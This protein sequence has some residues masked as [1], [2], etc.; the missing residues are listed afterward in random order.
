MAF[1]KCQRRRNWPSRIVP[2]ARSR[3]HGELSRWAAVLHMCFFL[4]IKSALLTDNYTRIDG[5]GRAFF[6]MCLMMDKCSLFHLD[7]WFLV[8]YNVVKCFPKC[9]RVMWYLIYYVKWWFFLGKNCLSWHLT[10]LSSSCSHMNESVKFDRSQKVRECVA[11]EGS[12]EGSYA[13]VQNTQWDFSSHDKNQNSF[14][15]Y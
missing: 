6:N 11:S 7:T 1:V 9:F 12:R 13:H 5:D 14:C 3:R 4:E 15:T 2:A 10:A 8:R